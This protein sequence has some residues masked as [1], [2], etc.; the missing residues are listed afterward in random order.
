MSSR[1]RGW[2]CEM[3]RHRYSSKPQAKRCAMQDKIDR[4]TGEQHIVFDG[5]DSFLVTTPKCYSGFVAAFTK[6]LE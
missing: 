3:C 1:L 5:V 6:E 4:L 2:R